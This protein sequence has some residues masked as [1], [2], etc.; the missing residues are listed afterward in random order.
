MTQMKQIV[1]RY[2]CD[3]TAKTKESVKS[4]VIC[5]LK[6]DQHDDTDETDKFTIRKGHTS[7]AMC[8]SVESVISVYKKR[9]ILTI[10]VESDQK[11]TN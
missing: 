5:W 10:T 6:T 8:T 2:T 7:V 3:G 1:A 9:I 11:N 4:R